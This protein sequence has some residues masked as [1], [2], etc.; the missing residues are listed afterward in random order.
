MSHPAV[1]EIAPDFNLRG[2]GGS[3]VTLSEFRGVRPVVVAFFPLAFSPVCSHQLPALQKQLPRLRAL[4]AEVLGVSVD[5]HYA[6]TEFARRLGLDFPLLS[7]WDHAASEA[8]GVYLPQRRYSNRALFLVDRDGRVAHA[9]VMPDPDD[10]PDNDPL[11]QAL[12]RIA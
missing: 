6:N 12:E 1:G 10:I 3:R 7:D 4:G 11:I 8:Y 5:S 2:P 9:D